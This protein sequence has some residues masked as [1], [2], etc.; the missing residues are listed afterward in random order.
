M[1]GALLEALSWDSEF[2]GVPIARLVPDQ[3]DPS[4]LQ[5]VDTQCHREGIRC[6]YALVDPSRP[7]ALQAMTLQ[8][9]RLVDLRVTLS[10]TTPDEEG[11]EKEK[12]AI[13]IA[14]DD[15]IC[16]L[17]A[18]ARTSHHDTRYYADPGFSRSRCDDL[19]AA[20]IANSCRGFADRVWVAGPVGRPEG[21]LTGSV[22]G[23]SEE[24]S[25]GLFAIAP[26]AQGRGLGGGL[27]RTA[28]AWFADRGCLRAT[29][30]TQARN[31][32]ALGIY[33]KHGFKIASI[34]V[35]LHKWYPDHHG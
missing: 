15:D 33:Q 4:L 12:D 24:G 9:Y 8:G 31:R 1:T 16:G 6:L 20:W 14:T 34:K 27:L 13:R 18:I 32:A 7:D 3:P 10:R 26:S 17:E 28:L 19:Y 22:N 21:Y 35:W 29:V 30:V 2:F 5:E 25:I 23:G 11:G